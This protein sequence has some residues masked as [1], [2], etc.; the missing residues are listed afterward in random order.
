MAKYASLGAQHTYG[1]DAKRGPKVYQIAVHPE[2]DERE[3]AKLPS[4]VV[5]WDAKAAVITTTRGIRGQ[6]RME[7]TDALAVEAVDAFVAAWLEARPIEVARA[8]YEM[9]IAALDRASKADQAAWDAWQPARD[10]G[11]PEAERLHG[12][13]LEA[14]AAEEDAINRADAAKRAYLALTE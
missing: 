11:E 9:T 7:S 2:G 5:E 6:R 1:D 10:K 13:W 3:A 14:H 4:L 12:A 8:R